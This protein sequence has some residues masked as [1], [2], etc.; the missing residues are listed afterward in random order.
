VSKYS[1]IEWTHHTF[2]PW[3]GCTKISDGCKHCYAA[4]FAHRLGL[5]VWG[6]DAERRRF[7]DAHWREPLLWDRAAERAGERHRVFCASMADVFED[8]RDL[9]ADRQRLAALID[10]TPH[11]DWLLLTKRPDVMLRLWPFSEVRHNVWAGTTVENQAAANARIPILLE[12]PA[13]VRFLSVEP[14]IGDLDLEHAACVAKVDWVIVGGES[15]PGAR[16]CDV[17][18]I[19]GVVEQCRAA[20]V[21]C[22][23]KQLGSK[24]RVD[25][26]SWR[27][28]LLHT[29]DRKGG[30]PAEWPADLRVREFPPVPADDEGMGVAS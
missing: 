3:W 16:P 24:P 11:L 22:F 8:R 28:V 26:V 1:A 19:R 13:A 7:G 4:T 23:V 14:L 20:G 12:V 30:D 29:L 6:Q 15:G 21:P 18:W 27:G 5:K 17:A 25:E 2:N 9:D 10:A